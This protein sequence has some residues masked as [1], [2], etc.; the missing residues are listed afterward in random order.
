MVLSA[1]VMLLL[2]EAQEGNPLSVAFSEAS[3]AGEF[4]ANLLTG[5]LVV[6]AHEGKQV[7]VEFGESGGEAV[8]G[9]GVGGEEWKRV[10]PTGPG[11]TLREADNVVT[12]SLSPQLRSPRITVLVPAKTNLKLI[13]TGGKGVLV[14]GITG[15]IEIRT[16]GAGVELVEVS[17]GVV[18]R[19]LKGGVT[20]KF[21]EVN[22]AK[23]LQ[24]H[25]A[26]GR[27]DVTLPAET[28]A[29]L[30]ME[31]RRGKVFT[32]FVMK[33]GVQPQGGVTEGEINGGGV[34]YGFVTGTGD[35]YIRKGI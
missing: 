28:K 10:N 31:T 32:N 20:A 12:L 23:E 11:V 18:A 34:N 22:P 26:H 6:R 14:E 24:F 33:T 16:G 35:I 5:W 25:S 7:Q 30:R 8:R 1:V 29:R 13:S 27:I 17:G 19:T 9:E 2:V 15:D 21:K 3:K 4:R